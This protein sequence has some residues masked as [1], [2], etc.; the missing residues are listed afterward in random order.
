MGCDLETNSTETL[1]KDEVEEVSSSVGYTNTEETPPIRIGF[2]AISKHSP[3]LAD[4]D[5]RDHQSPFFE[6]QNR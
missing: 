3:A 6:L 1:L 4:W 2:V 5:N